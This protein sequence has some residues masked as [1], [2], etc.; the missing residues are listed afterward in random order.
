MF[1]FGRWIELARRGILRLPGCIV[2]YAE[3]LV[4][5][6]SI[7]V[8]STSGLVIIGRKDGDS[9]TQRCKST[10]LLTVSHSRAL[11]NNVLRSIRVWGNE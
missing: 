2:S 1:D 9:L 6:F 7:R 3:L 8:F 4:D 10:V 11:Q 5:D